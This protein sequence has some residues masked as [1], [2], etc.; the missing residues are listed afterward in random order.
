LTKR[1]VNTDGLE[2]RFDTRLDRF[3]LIARSL[4]SCDGCAEGLLAEARSQ[5]EMAN[6]S[7]DFEYSFAIRVVVRVALAHL[8]TFPESR[9]TISLR[10]QT[11]GCNVPELIL[12]ALPWS[13]RAT[14]FIRDVLGYSRRECP[15]LM[16]MSDANVDQIR[17]VAREHIAGL[18]GV[19]PDSIVVWYQHKLFDSDQPSHQPDALG[20]L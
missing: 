20:G 1:P 19:S 13:E 12:R 17:A 8:Q 4:I 5:T 14:F 16:E 18:V 10:I 3:L 7:T 6:I 15:L 11:N 2:W 9:D